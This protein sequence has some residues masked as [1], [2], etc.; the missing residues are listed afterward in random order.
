M[1]N[2]LI[3]G[4]GSRE[5]AIAKTF[6]KIILFIIYLLVLEISIFQMKI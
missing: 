4:S 3:L 1:T 5:H 2:I 6:L